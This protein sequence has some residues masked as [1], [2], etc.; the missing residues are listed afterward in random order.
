[1][2]VQVVQAWEDPT[3]LAMVVVVAMA[4]AMHL[5]RDLELAQAGRV[6]LGAM[7]PLLYQDQTLLHLL[8]PVPVELAQPQVA[9]INPAVVVTL[10]LE[11]MAA[12]VLL[13]AALALV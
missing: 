3:V 8:A 1:M 12:V 6:K 9:A 11:T 10:V 13:E 4:V 5:L 7:Q 2:V